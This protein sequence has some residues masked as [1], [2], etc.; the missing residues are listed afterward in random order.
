MI[1]EMQIQ[2]HDLTEQRHQLEL[3]MVAICLSQMLIAMVKLTVQLGLH[4]H[5]TLE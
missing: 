5:R 4:F 1:E 3:S 2:L